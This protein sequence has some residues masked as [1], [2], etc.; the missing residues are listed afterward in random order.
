MAGE[1]PKDHAQALALFRQRLDELT[2]ESAAY[3]EQKGSMNDGQ[4]IAKLQSLNNAEE[5]LE[6]LKEYNQSNGEF[7]Q[8]CREYT[9]LNDE[10]VMDLDARV[11]LLEKIFGLMSTLETMRKRV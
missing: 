7:L 4:K 5:S 11:R 3:E 1:V 6:R 9:A 2:R 8:L 10:G